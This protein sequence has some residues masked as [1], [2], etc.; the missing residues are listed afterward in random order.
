MEALYDK[1]KKD[2]E[3]KISNNEYGAGAFLPS[4]PELQKYYHV[5][6]TT[7]REAISHLVADGLV[8][9]VRGKGTKV[10][11]S[12]L[13]HKISVLM[14]FTEI[15]QQQGICPAISDCRTARI[16][17]HEEVTSQLNLLPEEEVYEIYR[18]RSADNEPISINQSYI[19]CGFLRD[20]DVNIFAETQSLYNALETHYDLSIQATED[21]IT[22]IK[23]TTLQAQILGIKKNDPILC[24]ERL[25]YNKN[26]TPVEL[27]KIW[28]RSDRYKHIIALRKR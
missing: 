12:K 7:I 3:T 8:T 21:S 24:I 2:I 17:P 25:A 20:F 27:S 9:I 13:S 23:A 19:P 11:P 1:V 4:E 6:R 14:S 26:N 15:M 18:V 5:S 10:R 16:T 22:A 28:I